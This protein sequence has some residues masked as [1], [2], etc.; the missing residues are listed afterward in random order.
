M[1]KSITVKP[2]KRG[3]PATG[4]DPLVGI[5]MPGDLTAAIDRYIDERPAPKPSRSAAIRELL[6]DHL[7]GLGILKLPK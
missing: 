5:R 6:A 3:R 7:V 1:A 2:K 4:R